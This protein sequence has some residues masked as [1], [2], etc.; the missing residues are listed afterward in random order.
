MDGWPPP[1][2][3][4]SPRLL[5]PRCARRRLTAERGALKQGRQSEMSRRRGVGRGGH[6]DGQ[7][8]L[9]A[10]RGRHRVAT[11]SAPLTPTVGK[12]PGGPGRSTAKRASR[13]PDPPDGRGES[14]VGPPA[15]PGGPGA[16][17][18]PSRR[19]QGPEAHAPAVASRPVP[20]RCKLRGEPST[21]R[22]SQEPAARDIQRPGG[23]RDVPGKGAVRRTPS[24]AD[25]WW[26]RGCTQAPP[27]A[28]LS[29]PGHRSGQG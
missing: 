25:C 16:A 27:P 21:L 28:V 23:L 8:A 15:H 5:S 11:S 10:R 26:L 17:R 3:H 2:G 9:R 19:T 13:S 1:W 20:G 4:F 24:D 6:R 29:S 7:G 22:G 14:D 12:S 18:L